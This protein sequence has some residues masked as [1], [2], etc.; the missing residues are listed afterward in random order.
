[1]S[2]DLKLALYRFSV[3][4]SGKRDLLKFE[5]VIDTVISDVS[6]TDKNEKYKKFIESYINSFNGEFSTNKDN[7]K[8]LSPNDNSITFIASENVIHGMIRGGLSNIAQ[9]IYNK[10]NSKTVKNQINKD[11]IAA[12]D[13]YF[14]LWTPFHRDLG[15]LMVQYYSSATMTSVLLDNLSLFF[16]KL[17]LTL[18]T[19]PF[20][21]EEDKKRFIE[22]SLIKRIAFSKKVQTSDARRQFEPLLSEEDEFEIVVELRK[23]NK[24]SNEFIGKIQNLLKSG[25]KLFNGNFLAEERLENFEMK[26]YYE[27]EQ[28]RKA[29]A[30]LTDTFDILP[31]IDLPVSL[32][33]KDSDSPDINLIKE[34]CLKLLN[35]IKNE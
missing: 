16:R 17:N 31:T 7:T 29:H 13:Y 28:G 35:K 22:R 32:K 2:H 6:I 19:Y 5:A 14:L 30:K 27:D 23:I 9:D 26:I 20:V 34:F 21:P 15:I 11:D 18:V 8:S 1:M 33:R 12:L 24:N 25:K 3:K 10:K 4:G